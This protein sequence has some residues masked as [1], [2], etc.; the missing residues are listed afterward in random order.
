MFNDQSMQQSHSASHRHVVV[1]LVS[2]YI[3]LWG[4]S[5]NRFLTNC[6]MLTPSILTRSSNYTALHST[7]IREGGSVLYLGMAKEI[8]NLPWICIT[9]I[10]A[11][12]DTKP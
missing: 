9:S 7:S 3:E 5:I 2:Y 6:T 4:C 11:K 12:E 10:M 8:L 1:Y